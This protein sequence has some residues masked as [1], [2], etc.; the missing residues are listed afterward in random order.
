[1]ARRRK[2]KNNGAKV[3]AI[4]LIVI[5]VIGL[6]VVW[7]TKGNDE[8]EVPESQ[9][10]TEESAPEEV[11]EEEPAPF[12]DITTLELIW[13][14]DYTVEAQGYIWVSSDTKI[15]DVD[16]GTI[17]PKRTGSCTVTATGSD[18]VH[19]IAVTVSPKI[20]E[21]DGVT[22]VN[23][24][25]IA[26]KTYSVP[27]DFGGDND[28]AWAA[29]DAMAAAAAEEGLSIYGSSVY[30]SYY[31]QE[32]IYYRELNDYGIDFA[33]QSTARPGHSE[34][35]TGLAFDLNSITT[36]FKDTPEGIWVAEHCHE[37]GFILRYMEGKE[38]LTGYMY[39]PW[40][41]R[42][43]GEQATDIHYSGLCLE[44]YLGIDS[45]YKD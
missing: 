32:A 13:G 11:V 17:I 23:G 28:E 41:F 21:I 27:E 43:I 31:T 25:L 10:E 24:I 37:Y 42:Y 20:E 40:H 2:K 26:N 38:H 30:R 12:P 6:A 7:A 1:M 35:Q 18:G 4:A 3:F 5:L 9:P 22:Y 29:F 44:E 15:A 19:E 14:S 16:N 45:V 36:D 34:H 33:D 8:P 39:E